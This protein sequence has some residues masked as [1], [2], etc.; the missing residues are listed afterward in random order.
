MAISS[1][2]IYMSSQ[3]ENNELHVNWYGGRFHLQVK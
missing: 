1:M 2:R 3:M